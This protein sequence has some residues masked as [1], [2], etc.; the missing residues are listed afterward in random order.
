MYGS[1]AGAGGEPAPVA[2]G[3]GASY[4]SKKIPSPL[5]LSAWP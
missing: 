5:K 2:T 4:V 1:A 3:I